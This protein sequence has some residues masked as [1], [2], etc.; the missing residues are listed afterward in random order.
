MHAASP[1]N[2]HGTT[3]RY[4]RGDGQL[5]SVRSNDF[6]LRLSR[7][8]NRVRASSDQAEHFVYAKFARPCVLW[9]NRAFYTSYWIRDGYVPRMNACTICLWLYDTRRFADRHHNVV[10]NANSVVWSNIY[11]YER[12]SEMVRKYNFYSL[13]VRSKLLKAFFGKIERRSRTHS[14]S[15]PR[16]ALDAFSPKLHR[17]KKKPKILFVPFIDIGRRC[18]QFIEY[19]SRLYNWRLTTLCI[20]IVHARRLG[21]IIKI[22]L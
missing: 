21:Y 9:F 1:T 16:G 18:I 20:R 12:S 3:T 8:R 17:L 11:I 2:R 22:R 7:K 15:H 14:R 4:A 13:T 19:A 6:Q 10:E 5:V